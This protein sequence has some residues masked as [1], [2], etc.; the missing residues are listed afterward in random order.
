[1][2][3]LRGT[4]DLKFILIGNKNTALANWLK[5]NGIGFYE[6]ANQDY[7]GYPTKWLRVF[8]ILLKEKPRTVHTHLWTANLI[9]LSTAWVLRIKQRV[10]TRHH[11]MIHYNEFPSGRKW[12]RL[13]N[14]LATQVVAISRN[15]ESI[16]IDKD[17][18]YPNKVKLIHHGFDLKY[19]EEPDKEKV[20]S[21]KAKYGLK[22]FPVVGVISRYLKLK[23]IQ[24]TIEAFKMVRQKFPNAKLVLAN[25]VG[26]YEAAIK[27]KL[28]EL[29]TDSYIEIKFEPDLASLYQT[30][31][32]F[33]HVP[34]DLQSEA[35]GQTYIEPLVAGIPSVFTM[36]GVAPEFI[37]HEKNALVVPYK[38]P[39][40]VAN[41]I[42]RMFAEGDLK[43]RLIINGRESVKQFNVDVMINQL[44]ELYEA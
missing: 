30:F 43:Q 13:C 18:C 31:H 9:G 23:G 42:L 26:N 17:G 11:A 39:D 28:K 16:L 29:P 25:S 36:S 27:Q 2:S 3:G 22:T 19:F 21:M 40:S 34:H 38:D 20:E 7:S 5:V 8:R 35:F 44:K 14:F 6:V 37:A 10:Y 4:F 32:V 15:V 41:A 12:D 24:Y 1:V 33:V